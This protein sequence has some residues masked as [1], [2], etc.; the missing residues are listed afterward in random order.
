MPSKTVA[1]LKAECDLLGIR[2]KA[3]APK[4]D[5]IYLILKHREH[6]R[7]QEDANGSN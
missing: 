3:N 2:Y 4:A 7:K 5:L 6:L 1:E